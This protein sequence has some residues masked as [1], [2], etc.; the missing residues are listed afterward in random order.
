[1][2]R[3]T[4]KITIYQLKAEKLEGE[5]LSREEIADLLEELE[6]GLETH[7][8]LMIWYQ[9]AGAIKALRG[10]LGMDMEKMTPTGGSLAS[11]LAR[12]YDRGYKDGYEEA[13]EEAGQE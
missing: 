11:K 2:K 10:V 3:L 12:E 5:M 8:N 1:M 4:E 6:G 13:E 7:E 9:V